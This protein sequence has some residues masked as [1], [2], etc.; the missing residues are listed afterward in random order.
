MSTADVVQAGMLGH[1]TSWG[2]DASILVGEKSLKCHF[3]SLATRPSQEGLQHPT[4]PKS[5]VRQIA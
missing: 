3:H 2:K 4:A 5:L 1:Q